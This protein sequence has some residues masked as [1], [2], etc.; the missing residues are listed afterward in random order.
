MMDN[1]E[2]ENRIKSYIAESFLNEDQARTLTG[3][4]DLLKILDSLQILRTVMHVE[5]SFGVKIADSDMSPDTLG[6][7]HKLAAYVAA[8]GP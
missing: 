5:T 8:R 3:D 6:S 4:D 2:I 1:R 7:V